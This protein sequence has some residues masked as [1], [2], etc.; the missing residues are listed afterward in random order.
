MTKHNYLVTTPTSCGVIAEAFHIADPAG[1]A[2][3]S[4]SRGRPPA[5][6][7]AGHPTEEEVIRPARLPPGIEPNGA[8][9]LAAADRGREAAVIPPG[10][11]PTRRAWTT[12]SFARR[13]R[14][15]SSRCSARRHRRDPPSATASWGHGWKHVNRAIQ[16]ADDLLFAIGMRFDDRV[17][18]NVGRSPM[19]PDHPWTSTPRRSANVAVEV[20]IVGDAARPGR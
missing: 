20:L 11:R 15:R 1:R 10:R 14:S 13:P 17:T 19:R 16:S 6:A 3:P 5:G 8:S 9:S 4:T 18:G 7:T 12:S 2:R